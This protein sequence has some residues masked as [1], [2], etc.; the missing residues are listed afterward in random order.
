M[1]QS[2]LRKYCFDIFKVQVT[3]KVLISKYYRFHRIF[4]AAEPFATELNLTVHD[5]VL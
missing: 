1:R 5:H 4:R 3:M 2:V